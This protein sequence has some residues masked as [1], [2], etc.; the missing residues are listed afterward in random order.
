[1]DGDETE[2]AAGSLLVGCALGAGVARVLSDRF[3]RKTRPS[4]IGRDLCT[5]LGSNCRY[6]MDWASLL[7]RGLWPRCHRNRF[8]A[9][10]ALYRRVSPAAI[11]G[12]WSA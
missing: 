2:F 9:A 5:F 7:Q 4:V 3:G 8:H 11:R 6:P 12:D 1:M 10:A